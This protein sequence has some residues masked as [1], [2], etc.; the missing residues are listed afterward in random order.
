MIV[1]ENIYPWIQE[2]SKV[3]KRKPVLWDNLHA[4][5]YD[6]QRVFLGPYIG[7][8]SENFKYVNTSCMIDAQRKK[9]RYIKL[10]DSRYML[11]IYINLFINYELLL[12]LD[13]DFH[14]GVQHVPEYIKSFSI[15]FPAKTMPK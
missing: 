2:L 8:L 3:I 5:D 7:G 4:N 10:I 12:V 11:F 15:D 9:R 13:V 6:I 1:W 14:H